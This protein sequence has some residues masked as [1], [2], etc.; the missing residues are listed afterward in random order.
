MKTEKDYCSTL[1][2]EE[3]SNKWVVPSVLFIILIGFIL[4]LV[5]SYNVHNK[6]A[7]TPLQ[8]CVSEITKHEEYDED[9]YFYTYETPQ[10]PEGE[11]LPDPPIYTY[12]ITII[13]EERTGYWSCFIECKCNHL[14]ISHDYFKAEEVK[15]IDCDLIYEVIYNEQYP[16]L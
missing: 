14:L 9:D 10:P 15:L 1:R 8:W 16:I 3:G 13:T 5:I 12:L 7:K 6:G 2:K 11:K 4:F